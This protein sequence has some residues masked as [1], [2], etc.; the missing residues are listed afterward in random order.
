MCIGGLIDYLLFYV[1]PKNFSYIHVYRDVTNTGE[2]LT[3][4]KF[5]RLRLGKYLKY[6][7]QYISINKGRIAGVT[8]QQRMLTPL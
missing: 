4:V 6:A 2:G 8:G 1:A 7:Y 5:I 3:G